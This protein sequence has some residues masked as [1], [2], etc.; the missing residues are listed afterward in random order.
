M[1]K[2]LF[3]LFLFLFFS[4]EMDAQS[5]KFGDLVY[6]TSLTN[7]QVYNIL[8]QGNDFRQESATEVNGQTILSFKNIVNKTFSEKIIVG[9]ST[10]AD[11]GT[12]LRTVQYTSTDINDI[13]YMISQAKIYGLKLGFRGADPDN[14]IYLYDNDFYHVVIHLRRDQKSGSVEIRQKELMGFE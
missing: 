8:L 10:T 9:S 13:L 7:R 4:L 1:K 5:I 14:N 3:F 11:D 12:I 6:F 2:N